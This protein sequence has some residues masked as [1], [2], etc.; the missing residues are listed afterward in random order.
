MEGKG[1]RTPIGSVVL[2]VL[3][4]CLVV[5]HIQVEAVVCCQG[6]WG[7]ACHTACLISP[8]KIP[9]VT[10]ETTCG[11]VLA[12]QTCPPG[13][14]SIIPLQSSSA[15]AIIEFCKL[16][17]ASSVCNI[18]K[19]TREQVLKGS[20]IEQCNNACSEVCTNQGSTIAL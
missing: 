10:C 6:P 1:L 2:G 20:V 5:A 13:Y 17:C 9:F 7:R 16:G 12:D 19:S 15:S 11:C 14:P 4:L 8:V 3:I 18:G